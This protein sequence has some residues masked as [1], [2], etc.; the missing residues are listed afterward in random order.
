MEELRYVVRTGWKARL[1]GIVRKSET[2]H[3]AAI[4][5]LAKRMSQKKE[6]VRNGVVFC[7]K[8]AN[9]FRN[10]LVPFESHTP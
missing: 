3:G 10:T 5:L 7:E 9:A 6:H 8:S 2:F 4:G 1:T